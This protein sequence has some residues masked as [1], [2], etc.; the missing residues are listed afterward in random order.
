MKA[1]K[2]VLVLVVL[3]VVGV[4][5]YYAPQAFAHSTDVHTTGY[6][7]ADML[8]AKLMRNAHSVA[9]KG[10]A[11]LSNADITKANIVSAHQKAVG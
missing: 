5:L 2:V 9:T 6:V 4:S 11:F 3:V 8:H 10:G 1:F 7:N